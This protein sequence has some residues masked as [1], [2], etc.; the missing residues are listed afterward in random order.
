MFFAM[1]A[2]VVFEDVKQ[3]LFFGPV[4]QYPV[5]IQSPFREREFED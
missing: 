3:E 5:W 4:G 2:G 1:D